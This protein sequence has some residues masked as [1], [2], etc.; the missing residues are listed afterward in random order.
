MLAFQE[1]CSAWGAS[2]ARLGDSASQEG[3]QPSL[4]A[5]G[6][7]QAKWP[8]EVIPAQAAQ[9][10]TVRPREGPNSQVEDQVMVSL[11]RD[12]VV[13]PDCGRGQGSQLHQDGLLPTTPSFSAP[14]NQHCNFSYSQ[15]S[16]SQVPG[17]LTNAGEQGLTDFERCQ[18]RT[19]L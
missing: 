19:G 10:S 16:T 3:V 7:P 15:L 2:L 5:F 18:K 14:N 11:L 9:I 6:I 17:A 12:A 1:P 8:S 4:G 13:E